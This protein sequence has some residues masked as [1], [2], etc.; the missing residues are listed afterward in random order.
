MV[1]GS[2]ARVHALGGPT[3]HPQPNTALHLTASS[4]RSCLAPA[5]GGR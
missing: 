3:E 5:F 4:L 2:M 1:S